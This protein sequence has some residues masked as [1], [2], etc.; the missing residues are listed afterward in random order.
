MKYLKGFSFRLKAKGKQDNLLS[1]AAGCRRW[2]WNKA[3]EIQKG[4]LEAGQRFLSY[5]ELC[6]LLPRWKR[7]E[8]TEWLKEAP[9]Q[10][11]QQGLKDLTRSLKESFQG[12]GFP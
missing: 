11:L 6:A 4:R 7:E 9:S 8:G 5:S 10:T 1:Q 12:K 2:V 3:L